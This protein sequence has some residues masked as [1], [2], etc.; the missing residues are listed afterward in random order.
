M[1]LL[2]CGAADML[3]GAMARLGNKVT[4]FGAF[5][6]STVDRYCDVLLFLGIG[7]YYARQGN[8]TYQVLAMVGMA[9]ALLISYTKA[10]SEDFIP[11]CRVGYWERGERSAALLIA[12]GVRLPRVPVPQRLGRWVSR[13]IAALAERPPV[14]RALVIGLLA[15]FLP[16]GWLYAFAITAAGTGSALRGAVV[17]AVFWVGTL[18]VMTGIGY[19][20]QILARPLRRQVPVFCSVALIAVGLWT[21]LARAQLID[22]GGELLAGPA[23]ASL[24]DAVEQVR[25]RIG[26][27][28]EALPKGSLWFDPDCGLKTRTPEE[29]QKKLEVIIA[30]VREAR[31]LN[32]SS[33]DES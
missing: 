25:E 12:T 22:P 20:I 19:G 23:P 28:V 7:I 16:C 14:I 18:P 33:A 31:E 10:R 29:S 8:V 30:A 32:E 15:T 17:M 11:S 5:L 26:H 4:R 1:A 6:D 9:N 3:D 13:S 2:L 24:Q 21:V 27:A